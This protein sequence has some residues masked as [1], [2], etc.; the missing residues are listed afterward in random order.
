MTNEGIAAKPP[1]S[2]REMREDLPMP[3][4]ARAAPPMAL[5]VGLALLI[6]S[7]VRDNPAYRG[8]VVASRDAAS[9][10]RSDPADAPGSSAADTRTAGTI[11][12]G[13]RGMPFPVAVA[14][15]IGKPTSA[16]TV[17]FLLQ[18]ALTCSDLGTPGWDRTIGSTQVLEMQMRG[19]TV[20]TYRIGVD[21]AVNYLRTTNNPDASSGQ[22]VLDRLD[23]AGIASGTFHLAFG[24]DTLEGSFEA[25]YCPSGVEP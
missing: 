7:C 4:A 8:P 18:A 23:A 11:T 2:R 10:L 15:R 22:V 1:K 16:P 13:I 3:R 21:A 19:T 24:S 6:G 14:W 20:R 9:D 5:A 25:D 17:I 12:G